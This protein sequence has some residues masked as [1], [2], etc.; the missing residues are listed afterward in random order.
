MVSSDTVVSY[1]SKVNCIL[2]IVT[3]VYPQVCV[4][5]A[6]PMFVGAWSMAGL[7]LIEYYYYYY[8]YNIKHVIYVAN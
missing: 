6:L 5:L 2:E 4:L 7:Q 1:A 8:Y 3:F